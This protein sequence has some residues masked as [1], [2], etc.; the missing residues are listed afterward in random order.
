LSA[1]FSAL[2]DV[3][4]VYVSVVVGGK[5]FTIIQYAHIVGGVDQS[6]NSGYQTS[7]IEVDRG[8]TIVLTTFGGTAGTIRSIAVVLGYYEDLVFR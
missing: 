7:P 3:S 6:N 2:C 4:D 5:T 8:S 1:S